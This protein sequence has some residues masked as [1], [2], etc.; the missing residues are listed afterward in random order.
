MEEI[1][2]KAFFK[3]EKKILEVWKIEFQWKKVLV[4]P[5]NWETVKYNTVGKNVELLQYT[6]LK[7]KDWKEI[8]DRDILKDERINFF[9][10]I[11]WHEASNGW[12]V[13]SPYDWL[14][15]PIDELWNLSK[16]KIVSNAWLEPDFW[17]E[18]PIL[19]KHLKK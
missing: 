2:F 8:Y 13:D 12:M 3:H 18:N 5:K 7:A 9:Y 11:F 6:W 16:Y 17:V 1:K 10:E 14:I 19:K 15:A 4:F